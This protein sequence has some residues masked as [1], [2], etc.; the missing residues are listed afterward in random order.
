MSD[1][2][3]ILI[4]LGIF[5]V[6]GV[7]VFNWWQERKFHQRIS[8]DFKPSQRDVLI[9]DFQVNAETT[10]RDKAKV[11]EREKLEPSIAGFD[12]V[13]D[14]Q[15]AFDSEPDFSPI[16]QSE[17][18]APLSEPE[19][20]S[21][22]EEIVSQMVDDIVHEPSIH[23][24]GDVSTDKPE[25]SAVVIEEVALPKDLHSQVDLI[26]LLYASS[27][28]TQNKVVGIEQQFKELTER[29]FAYGLTTTNDWIEIRLSKPNQAFTQLAYS[30]QLADRGG[31]VSRSTLNRF[32]H[33]VET[34]GLNLSAHVEWQGAGDPLGRA[35]ALDQFCIEVDKTVGFHLLANDG[36]SFH[37]TKLRGLVEAQGLVLADDGRFHYKS[38]LFDD[39][40]E[41]TI[42]NFEG[43]DFSSKML[44][45]AVMHGITFQLDI[46]TV[47]NNADAFDRMVNAARAIAKGVD[48]TMIDDNRKILG[49][50]H[51]EKIRQQLKMIN[52]KMIAKGIIPGSPQALRLFS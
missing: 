40:L 52:A 42:K 8:K 16:H 9:E 43:N 39:Q 37:A 34:I 10:K 18:H 19:A 4:V 22:Q 36:A 31:S 32:Q 46:P 2:L 13:E 51:L 23:A 29:T 7:L 1:L 12:Q 48:A 6:L 33:M 27:P 28:I 20:E 17:A 44:K 47:K 26:A 24:S 49:D 35:V 5:I 45:T 41:F 3:I 38:P 25:V 15:S 50:I 14:T 11:V 21:M 30:L